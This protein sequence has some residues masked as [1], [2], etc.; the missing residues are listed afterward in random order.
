MPRDSVRKT[1]PHH[2]KFVL[3]LAFR[4]TCGAPHGVIQPAQ[5]AFRTRI[6][7]AHPADYNVR[8]VVQVQTIPDQFVQIDF[9]WP[10]TTPLATPAWAAK[11]LTSAI[12]APVSASLAS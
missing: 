11:T 6:H 5:L 7:V 1:G 8:L 2:H 4:S 9:R 10:F 12:A 3:T